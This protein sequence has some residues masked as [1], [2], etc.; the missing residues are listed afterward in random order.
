MLGL[1]VFDGILPRMFFRKPDDV[2]FA[3]GDDGGNSG[4]FE[5]GGIRYESNEKVRENYSIT[6]K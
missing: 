6:C 3:D 4:G 1:S 2:D 5:S